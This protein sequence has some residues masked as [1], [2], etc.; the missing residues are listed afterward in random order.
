MVESMRKRPPAC[1]LMVFALA[2]Y[3]CTTGPHLAGAA[4]RRQQYLA[5]HTGIPAELAAAIDVGHVS[6][7]MT[8]EQVRA[9]LGEPLRVTAFA[10][11]DS[12]IWLF[13]VSRF[14]QDQMHSHGAAS[15]RLVFIGDRLTTI[16]PI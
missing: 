9:V 5:T 10:R 8:R 1:L 3:S 15:F 13:P 12:E 14:H 6:R 2:A 16:E 11:S 7:G 4:D